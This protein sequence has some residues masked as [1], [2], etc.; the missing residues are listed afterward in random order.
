MRE[1][2]CEL[3]RRAV[4]KEGLVSMN[5]KTDSSPGMPSEPAGQRPAHSTG[6]DERRKAFQATDPIRVV[7]VSA[8]EKEAEGIARTLLEERLIAC[9]NLIKGVH[10][11]YWWEGKIESG[12]ETMIVMKTPA[13]K[14][15]QLMRRV[16]SLHSYSV[17]EFLTLPILESNPAYAAW[18]LKET[19]S[20]IK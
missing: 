12:A 4:N 2:E 3:K 9:A 8:P 17:P 20:E 11:L 15:N 1:R 19:G 10:S 5:P 6:W 18:V 7:I 16:R 13:S 14:I